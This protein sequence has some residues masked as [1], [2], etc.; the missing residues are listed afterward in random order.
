MKIG[1]NAENARNYSQCDS[2]LIGDKCGAHTFPYIEV[3]NTT[4]RSSTRRRRRRSARTRSSTAGSAASRRG[5]GQHDRQRLLQGGLPRAADG[6]RGRSAEAALERVSLEGSVGSDEGM[7]SMLEIK[8]LHVRVGGQAD[9]EGHRPRRQR[10]RGARDHGAERL[11]Q[12]HARARARRARRRTRSPAGEVLLRGQGP[13]RD[14]RR[15]S[16]PARACSWRSSTR[17]RSPAST[18]S[19]S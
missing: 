5:R 2:L 10:R 1:K 7:L 15:R 4:A 19:T 14:G 16:A 3:K 12:E 6:V 8:N 11:R 13:A 18:T 9:P 17:S